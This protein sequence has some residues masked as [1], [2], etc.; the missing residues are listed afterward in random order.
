MSRP[1]ARAQVYTG[2]AV[3]D[4]SQLKTS[5]ARRAHELACTL[6]DRVANASHVASMHISTRCE[7]M[8]AEALRQALSLNGSGNLS[9]ADTCKPLRSE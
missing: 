1:T 4:T 6:L 7:D 5:L 9:H 8:R 3:V 2:L